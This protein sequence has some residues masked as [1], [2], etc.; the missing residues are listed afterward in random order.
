MGPCL[1]KYTLYEN[2]EFEVNVSVPWYVYDNIPEKDL[3]TIYLE[4]YK[5]C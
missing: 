5:N 2:Q 4:M 3:K 1:N